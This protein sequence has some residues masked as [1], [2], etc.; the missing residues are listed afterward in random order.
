MDIRDLVGKPVS[1]VSNKSYDVLRGNR[2]LGIAYS[3]PCIHGTVRWAH[4]YNGIKTLMVDDIIVPLDEVIDGKIEP[5][6][7]VV[8]RIGWEKA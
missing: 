6:R 1:V 5:I 3:S 8:V 2:R 4:N 7:A